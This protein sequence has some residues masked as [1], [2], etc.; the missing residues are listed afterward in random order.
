M[1]KRVCVS[2][3]HMRMRELIP[4]WFPNIPNRSEDQLKQSKLEKKLAKQAQEKSWTAVQN[5][6]KFSTSKNVIS[7]ESSLIY[8]KPLHLQ[9]NELVIMERKRIGCGW[10]RRTEMEKGKKI[11]RRNGEDG[12]F[13]VGWKS[14][15]TSADLPWW[16]ALSWRCSEMLTY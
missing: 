1:K 8:V 15:K 11:G 3:P 2:I 7:D 4:Y 14:A 10:G 12:R 6:Q 16:D 9:K 5:L 13:D